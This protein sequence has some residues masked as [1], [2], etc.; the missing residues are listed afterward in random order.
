MPVRPDSWLTPD[1]TGIGFAVSKRQPRSGLPD[2]EAQSAAW[3]AA[4]SAAPAQSDSDE[5]ARA[6]GERRTPPSRDGMKSK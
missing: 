4:S 6:A 3:G 5:Q 2:P 1:D